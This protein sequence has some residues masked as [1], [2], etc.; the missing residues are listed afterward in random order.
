MVMK[1]NTLK[2]LDID[3]ILLRTKFTIIKAYN[4]EIQQNKKLVFQNDEYN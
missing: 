4:R 2:Q 3:K 1:N